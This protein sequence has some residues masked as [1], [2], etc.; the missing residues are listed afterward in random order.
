MT[1][2]YDALVKSLQQGAEV[3]GEYDDD[4]VTEEEERLSDQELEDGGRSGRSATSRG[5]GAFLFLI[6]DVFIFIYMQRH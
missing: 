1:E 2:L 5:G 4:E 6:L 3:A